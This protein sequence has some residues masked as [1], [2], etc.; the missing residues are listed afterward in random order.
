MIAMS[1]I[2]AVGTGFLPGAGGVLAT[3]P[4]GSPFLQ[5]VAL[6]TLNVFAVAMLC[7][8]VRLILGPTLADR[9]I[10][11]DLIAALVVGTIAV[12]AVYT[13]QPMLIRTGI[14]VAL[15]AFVATVAFAL[16]LERRGAQ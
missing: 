13:D 12:Y 4:M 14:V 7:A 1:M 6:I 10:A 2:Q 5:V 9:V 3:Q 8:V 15:I 16:F 11:L